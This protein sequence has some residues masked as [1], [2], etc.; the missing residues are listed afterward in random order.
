MMHFS[1]LTWALLAALFR[2]ISD[3][4]Y[5]KAMLADLNP[6]GAALA[7]SFVGSLVIIAATGWPAL[8]QLTFFEI[9]LL[10]LANIFWSLQVFYHIKSFGTLGVSAN[11][12][13]D[14]LRFLVLNAIGLMFFAEVFSG[15]KVLGLVLIAASI[16][17]GVGLKDL[18]FKQG[19]IW[20]LCSVASGCAALGIEKY[21]TYSVPVQ[22]VVLS[23]F[24]LPTLLYLLVRPD[25]LKAAGSLLKEKTAFIVTSSFLYACTAYALTASFGFGTLSGAS[26]G[27]QSYV[28]LSMLLGII[29]LHERER[30]TAKLTAIVGCTA[31]LI[32]FCLA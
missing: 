7:N 15:Y 32:I 12:I 9:V 29:L 4:V 8:G 3:I 1:P 31:G 13:L 16:P 17:L 30:L 21:L 20:R 5:R 11:A 22:T 10:I 28:G 25:S 6:L 23:S 26:T 24:I 14:M 19:S 27:Y 2:S 18:T